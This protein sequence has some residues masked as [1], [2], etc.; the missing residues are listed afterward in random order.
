M[1]H[2]IP[3]VKQ[4]P[5]SL[6][7][8]PQEQ[9]LPGCRLAPCTAPFP[10]PYWRAAAWLLPSTDA[11]ML[12][13]RPQPAAA[14]PKISSFIHGVESP[15]PCVPSP[16]SPPW[17]RSSLPRAGLSAGAL[18]WPDRPLARAVNSLSPMV[19]HFC[20]PTASPCSSLPVAR[21]RPG[22]DASAR[23][24]RSQRPSPAR[25]PLCVGVSSPLMPPSSRPSSPSARA[26]VVPPPALLLS[27][28]PSLFSLPRWTLSTRAPFPLLACCCAVP[29]WCLL[30]ARQ[31]TQQSRRLRALPARYFVKPSGQ[32]AVDAHQLFTVFTQSQRRRRSPPVRP[33]RSLFD[34]VSTLFSCD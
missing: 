4:A 2:L 32:H 14:R 22:P 23:P 11:P 30:G 12:A 33:R 10:A 18:P 25:P 3:F 16:C 15:A 29:R 6:C 5:S 26:W 28:E 7:P 13:P 9:E 8:L 31:N 1:A 20:T 34:S 27:I 24:A 17:P 19:G 21:E